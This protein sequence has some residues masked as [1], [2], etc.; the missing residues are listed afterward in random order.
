MITLQNKIDEITEN[1]RFEEMRNY[2]QHGNTSC[3]LHTVAVA[4][5]SIRLANALNIS[6]KSDELMRGAL[7]HDYFLYDWHDG[8][9]ERRIHGFTHP[10]KA[11]DNAKE[12]FE[13]TERECD[14]IKR[15]MFPL[16]VIP[17][18]YR[19]SIIVCIVD[20]CCSLYETFNKKDTY[21]NLKTK[22]NF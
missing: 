9:K 14:I 4:Y 5:Y 11:L 16:T 6:V 21:K 22:Y 20:K 2:T 1:S 15:H 19:E 10:S 12:D 8:K 13:L 3:F 17:P 18:K 7:L